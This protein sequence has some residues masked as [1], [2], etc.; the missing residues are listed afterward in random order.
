MLGAMSMWKEFMSCSVEISCRL[1]SIS[2]WTWRHVLKENLLSHLD[3]RI[4]QLSSDDP[5]VELT[6]GHVKI[7]VGL[8]TIKSG[9]AMI[10]FTFLEGW[11]YRILRKSPSLSHPHQSTTYSLSN[12]VALVFIMG[13]RQRLARPIS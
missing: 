3:L 5:F 2:P 1:K 4:P 8:S 9:C 11:G 10:T 13:A 6:F 7:I 12:Q